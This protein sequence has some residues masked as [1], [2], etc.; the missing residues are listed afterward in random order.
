[1]K[2]TDVN[3]SVPGACFWPAGCGLTMKACSYLAIT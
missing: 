2:I 3:L 1:L